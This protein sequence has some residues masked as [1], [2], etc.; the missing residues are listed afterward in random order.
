[1]VIFL[2]KNTIVVDVFSYHGSLYSKTLHRL[3]QLFA[4][5]A[6]MIAGVSQ[7]IAVVCLRF[8]LNKI[9]LNNCA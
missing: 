6:Q 3:L 4:G 5:F 9:C 2:A 7:I 1:M 8:C